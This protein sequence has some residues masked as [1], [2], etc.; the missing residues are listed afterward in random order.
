MKHMKWSNRYI[1][2]TTAISILVAVLIYFPEWLS[3][4]GKTAR[5]AEN[6]AFP[7][8]IPV[9]VINESL[10]TLIS[11][12]FLFYLNTAVF[13]FNRTSV[14]IT[15]KKML[16]SFGLIWIASSLLSKS[17][18][19]LH[20]QFDWPAIH[21]TIH[22]FLHPLRDLIIS[23]IVC[24]SCYLLYLTN[25]NQQVQIENQQLRAENLLNQFEA[26]KNQLNPHMLFNSLNTLRSLIRETPDKAQDYLQE[27]SYVLRY[28]LQGGESN[29]VSLREEMEFVNA[30]TFLLKMRYEDNLQFET[31]TI[32]EDIA[33]KQLPPISVQ[34]LIENAVKHNE[35]SNRKPLLIRV[36]ADEEGL[37]VTN[38]VQP[39]L[40]PS[41]GTGIGLN[42]LA[43]RYQLLYKKEITVWEG[44]GI[45]SVTLP[46]I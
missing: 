13:R 42:N 8:I 23:V 37:T 1:F 3:L 21:S 44:N 32:P 39:K 36:V 16:L 4:V 41:R 7:G 2:I 19:F 9:E 33:A 6:G 40:T 34:I 29:S 35:I 5:D 26:L 28:T 43:K 12:L 17:F 27:L 14:R 10:F 22:I 30:Y 46:L 11:L 45:F 38:P 15:W 20:H 31:D 24:I 25:K 18:M